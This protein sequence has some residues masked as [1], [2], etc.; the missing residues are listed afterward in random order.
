[1]FIDESVKNTVFELA[2]HMR[3]RRHS[4]AGDD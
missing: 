3:V 1:M 4:L 2:M